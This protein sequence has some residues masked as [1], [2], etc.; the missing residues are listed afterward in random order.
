MNCVVPPL[1]D[2]L[3]TVVNKMLRTKQS[4]DELKE[5]QRLYTRPQNCE[6]LTTTRVNAEIWGKLQSHTRSVT[7][8]FNSV[9]QS[10]QNFYLTY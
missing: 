5:K 6:T 9:Q 10:T 1:L 4:E 3:A 8:V 7:H 2:K